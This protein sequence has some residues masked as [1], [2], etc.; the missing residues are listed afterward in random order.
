VS[1]STSYPGIYIQE[2]SSSSHAI[3]PA[4]TSIAAFVGYSHP[5]QTT[6]FNVAQQCFSFNDYQTFFGP[7]FSSG[8]VDAS[9]PRAVNQF[10]L[11]GGSTAWV[12]GLQAGLFD[13]ND[14]LIP[15]MPVFGLAS[16]QANASGATASGGTAAATFTVNAANLVPT[17]SSLS[18]ASIP[19]NTPSFDLTINGSNFVPGATVSWTPQP[20]GAPVATTPVSDTQLIVHNL[21]LGAAANDLPNT[22]GVVQITVTN[23]GAP[24][25]AAAALTVSAASGPAAI[26]SFSPGS[27]AAG[28]PSF[29]LTINGSN[30]VS[31]ATISWTPNTPTTAPTATFVSSTQLTL[32]VT[33][34]AAV[35]DFPN[36]A[37]PVTITVTNL[38]QPASP[39]STFTVT[40]S[41]PTPVLSS[42]SPASVIA[43]GEAFT[44]TLNGSNFVPASTVTLSNGA[45]PTTVF[46]NN[47]QLMV[48]V[49]ASAIASATTSLTVSVSNPVIGGGGGTSA[50]IPLAVNAG[51]LPAPTISSVS[52]ASVTAGYTAPLTL[53]INGA[54]FVPGSTVSLNGAPLPAAAVSVVS[55]TQL[56]IQA[57]AFPAGPVSVTVTNP[58]NGVGIVFTAKEFTDILPMTVTIANVRNN[59]GTFDAVITYGSRIETYRGIQLNGTGNQQPAGVINAVSKLVQVAAAAG[60]YGTTIAPQQISL[61][62]TLPSTLNTCFS[63]ADYLPVFE[64]ASSLDNLEIFNLLL[65][66]GVTA[67]EVVSAALAFA[68][69]KRAFAILDPPPQAPAFGSS[70][71]TPQPI[72]YWMEGLYGPSGPVLPLSQNG[73]LYFPYL[74][75]NDPITG[76]NIPMAPSGF[77]AGVYASTDASRGVWKAPAGLA[78]NVKNTTGPVLSGVMN[79]PE[80]GVLNLD[81]INCLR[82]FSGA[83]TVVWGSR[84]LVAG[85]S[86]YQQSKYVPVR[87]MTLFIEQTLLA[88]LRWVVFE[89]NDQNLWIAIKSTIEAFLL[90]LYRQDALQGATPDDAFQVKCDSTT[91][92]PTDQQNGIVNIVV[93]FAPLKPAEFVIIQIAQLAGQTAGS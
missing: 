56:T 47:S 19:L 70:A 14:D 33:P 53:T 63:A 62:F 7:L 67:F 77:V 93:A 71:A 74:N 4:P 5:F 32:S 73:A 69:K 55:A 41:N 88:N 29:V 17:I 64:D 68:E 22:A 83:G 18:P 49:P 57:P 15:S 9:L 90:S 78:T 34:G 40:S 16:G 92:T 25:S 48:T 58:S 31:G 89:P 65:V 42:L 51:G 84:T 35:G 30:F 21:N 87:R 91:T 3:V 79:D 43:G 76:N 11:N 66:P 80:Q 12:V 45:S 24:T 20:P 23:P 13:S 72:Q 86:A 52:P 82:T 59:G 6:N 46:V 54:N 27:V 60:G 10:F 81:S 38:G 75:S 8:L 2:L 50:A 44:L 61:K 37:G 26:S 39:S 85:N 36:S 28:S 1:V